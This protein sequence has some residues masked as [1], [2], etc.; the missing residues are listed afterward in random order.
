MKNLIIA[1]ALTLSATPAWAEP[2]ELECEGNLHTFKEDVSPYP[3]S[4]IR[5][6]ID[7]DHN[8]VDVSGLSLYS[9]LYAIDPGKGDAAIIVFD[10]GLWKGSINRYNGALALSKCTTSECAR[11]DHVVNATCGKADPLF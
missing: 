11:Y 8:R 10:Y 3:V 5:L 6:L 4:G 7:E 2:V 9:A 1:A